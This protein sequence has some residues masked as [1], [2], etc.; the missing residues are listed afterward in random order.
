[1]SKGR[2][3]Q[4]VALLKGL[5]PLEG[6]TLS[7]LEGVRF[8]RANGP[9]ART[10]V[11]YDP[12]IIIVCQGRKRAFLGDDIFVYDAQHYLVLALP[13]PFS[14]EAE[15]SEA[16]PMLAVSLRL[17]MTTVA[18]LVMTL[19][20]FGA[21]QSVAPLG[22]VSTPL[23]ETLAEA[24]L[25]LLK[26]L[27]APVEARILGPGIVRE[28]CFHVLQGAQGASV[29]AAL[30]NHGPH[31]RIVK[32]LRRIHH[33][34]AERLDVSRLAAESKMSAAAFHTHFKAVTHTSPI[35]YI[36]CTRLHWARL[37]MI[38]D[39]LTAAVAAAKVGY[40]SPSQFSREFRRFFGRSPG[41]EKRNM[42]SAFLLRPGAATRA[43]LSRIE[44]LC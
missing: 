41:E 23:D 13:L 34:C 44:W 2:Q 24:T 3:Q 22:I 20:E 31:G 38:R 42:K 15:A 43:S 7:A 5:A 16:E 11:L 21:Q 25:R 27:A 36:K 32:A 4:M 12:S 10:P 33:N 9:L 40:E 1:M 17:D 8:M 6:S 37:I 26:V 19:D 35:Q 14:A 39:D 29:R 28:I 18:D 30:A